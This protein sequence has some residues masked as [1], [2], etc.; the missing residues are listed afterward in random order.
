MHRCPSVLP[1]DGRVCKDESG[2]L[3]RAGAG[4]VR[5]TFAGRVSENQFGFHFGGI[6]HSLPAFVYMNDP[7]TCVYRWAPVLGILFLIS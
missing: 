5:G 4:Q 2:E 6:V 1:E 7:C 3:C